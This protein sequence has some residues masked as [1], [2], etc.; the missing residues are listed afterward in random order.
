MLLGLLV[1]F[2]VLL[3][4][5]TYAQ[6]VGDQLIVSPNAKVFAMTYG[7]WTARWWQWAGFGLPE[8]GNPIADTSGVNCGLGQWG[9]V[10]FLAGTQGGAPVARS[11]TIPAGKGILI[12]LV[13]F[14]GS[15]PDDAATIE[16]VAVMTKDAVDL[17][18]LDTLALTIDGEAIKHLERYRVKT[19]F[20]SYT[21]AAPGIVWNG[22]SYLY[23]HC[24]EGFHAQAVGDGYWVLLNPLHPG[25]HN[26]YFHADIP[27]WGMT[28][29]VTYELTVVK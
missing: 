27:D 14:A 29:D 11:C 15:V 21:G 26:V 16:E 8:V 20:F 3:I 17:T 19:P 18:T 23:P 25:T 7:E 12:P 4:P 22:C 28:I 9:P 1:V 24:Y 5:R 2:A 6:N 13:A 10:F